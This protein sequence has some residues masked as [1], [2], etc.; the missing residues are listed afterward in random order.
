MS[1]LIE[2]PL[3]IMAIIVWILGSPIVFAFLDSAALTG[4]EGFIGG[5]IPWAVLIVLVGR[6]IYVVRS[7]YAGP[8]L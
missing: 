5:I 3:L 6:L 1:V 4:A 2:A 8:A 7:A